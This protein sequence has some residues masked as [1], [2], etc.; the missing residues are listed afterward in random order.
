MNI[1][2]RY[3][4]KKQ[5]FGCYNQLKSL[6]NENSIIKRTS[7]KYSDKF[8]ILNSFTYNKVLINYKAI[9]A[10]NLS[11]KNKNDM[12]NKMREN[13]IGAIVNNS[14]H[15]NYFTSSQRWKHIHESINIYLND[16][17]DNAE[18][19]ASV[20]LLHYG[21][22]RFNYDFT[23]K[24]N[25]ILSF[26]IELKY[27]VDSVEESPQFVSPM[28]PSQYM[29]SSYEEYFYDNYLPILSELSGLPLPDRK[30]YLKQIHT[31]IPV[32]MKMYQEL[33]YKGCKQS[34]KYTGNEKDI[35]F[36]ERAKEIDNESRS[37]FIE[38][39]DLNIELLS[40]YLQDTQKGKMYMLYK[41]NSF[42]MEKVNMGDYQLVSY[43]KLPHKYMYVAT[44]LSGKKIKILLRWKNGNGIA[45]PAFQIS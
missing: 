23:I 8:K 7:I 37:S 29:S 17:I 13:I 33:Y 4:V 39:N 35:E 6:C 26:N 9:N 21:G 22:R 2:L 42:K 20:K 12:N 25:Q 28:K 44:S 43:E 16:L 40:S 36:Y 1:R 15:G 19:I 10:F 18:P 11:V 31:N 38:N 41:N 32:C 14:T 34:S 27:N 45:Y 5:V 3:N 30:Q 24:I